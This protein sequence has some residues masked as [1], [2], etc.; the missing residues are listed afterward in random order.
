M[1]STLLVGVFLVVLFTSVVLV[2]QGKIRSCAPSVFTLLF[3]LF[4]VIIVASGILHV[5]LLIPNLGQDKVS[6]ISQTLAYLGDLNKTILGALIGIILP[7]RNKDH[8][9]DSVS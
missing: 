1:D 5:A 6:L 4:S 3:G 2:T 7:Q 9:G 8:N